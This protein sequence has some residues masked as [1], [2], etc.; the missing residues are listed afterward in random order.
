[1]R[2]CQLERPFPAGAGPTEDIYYGR[3]VPFRERL[4]IRFLVN[5]EMTQ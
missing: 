2:Y 4:I 1:M 5:L 3:P